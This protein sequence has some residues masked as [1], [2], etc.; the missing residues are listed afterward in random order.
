[1]SKLPFNSEA[2]SFLGDMQSHVLC[3]AEH[4]PPAYVTRI[5]SC[6][7]E[8]RTAVVHDAVDCH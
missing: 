6:E 8:L 3:H 2:G 5:R 7:R 4:K 1:M